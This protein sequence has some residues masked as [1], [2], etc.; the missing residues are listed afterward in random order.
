[1]LK[2][3][4][5]KMLIWAGH[6]HAG[7]ALAGVSF[8]ESSVFPLPPDILLI[9]MVITRR[10]R[11]IFY[12][13]LCTLA[14]VTGALLGYALGYYFFTRIGAPLLVFYGGDEI[15]AQFRNFYALWGGWII[16]GAAFSFL[17]FKVAT[18]ASGVLAID[19]PLFVTVSLLGRGLRFFLVAL[20]FYY[21]GE[22]AHKFIGRNF[23]TVS[24]VLVILLFAGFILIR[25]G[26]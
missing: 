21:M 6:R 25:Y 7:W 5:N 17:P 22:A 20:L 8:A 2:A 1:M 15:I 3:I 18:I 4:Y 24:I 12:A 26:F 10:R 19:V 16:F 23:N 9:P 11:A 14:S 13:V